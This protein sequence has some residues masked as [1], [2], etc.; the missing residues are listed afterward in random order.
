MDDQ[1]SELWH[2]WRAL[3][4]DAARDAL[5]QLHLPYAK[6]I[7]AMLYA[8]R[9]NNTIEFDDYLQLARMGLLEA[10]D[11]YDPAGGAQFRTFAARRMRGAVLDGLARFSE[12][13][14]QVAYRRRVLAERSA[15]LTDRSAPETRAGSAVERRGVVDSPAELFRYLAEVGVGLALGFMLENTGMF[16]AGNVIAGGPDPLYSAIELRHTRQQL[17]FLVGQLPPQ[18]CQVV[19]R[20]YLHGHGFDEIAT[21]LGLSKGRISQVHKKAL[22]SLRSLLADRQSCD[23]TG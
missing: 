3:G 13:S 6:V 23:R 21:E 15:S 16:D 7:A 9:P 18:E 5:L 22:G 20:H 4:E 19:T 1:E 11:R 12:Q 2:R 14:Q 17:R 10:F 8:R